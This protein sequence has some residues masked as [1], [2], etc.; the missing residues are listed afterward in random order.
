[1]PPL[2]PPRKAVILRPSV[3]LNR[4]QAEQPLTRTVARHA[5]CVKRHFQGLSEWT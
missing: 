1:M 2:N 4:H 5:L 3:P